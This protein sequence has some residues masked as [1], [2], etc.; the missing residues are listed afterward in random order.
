MEHKNKKASLLYENVIFIVLNVVFLVM[1]I[2]FIQMKGS[3]IAIAEEETAKQ[4][5]LLIDA[6]KPET[7]IEVDLKGFFEKAEGKGMKR[8][9]TIEIDK[10]R[11][12]VIV[13]GS[14]DS[15][16]EYSYFNDLNVKL[17]IGGDYLVLDTVGK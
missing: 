7:H 11:N 15:F 12:L 1:L 3:S 5:V 13:R 10:D 4:I 17:K 14:K 8:E 2:L 6:A 16:Y 9:K